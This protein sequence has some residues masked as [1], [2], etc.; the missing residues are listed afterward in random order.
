MKLSSAM[1]QVI[2]G[3]LAAEA[4]VW[5]VLLPWVHHQY[6]TGIAA[7]HLWKPVLLLALVGAGL[8]LGA[9]AVR[10]AMKGR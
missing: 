3:I 7:D 4:L 9:F 2:V 5:C 8:G 1:I 6:T 10:S